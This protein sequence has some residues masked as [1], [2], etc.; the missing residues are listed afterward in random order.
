MNYSLF[1]IMSKFNCK[2]QCSIAKV[3]I[4]L[5]THFSQ[6]PLIYL[7]SDILIG[8][9]RGE[10][11]IGSGNMRFLLNLAIDGVPRLLTSHAACALC[12]MAAIAARSCIM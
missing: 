10:G 8:S 5:F 4:R 6:A 9:G 2:T 11:H 12:S 7:L 3:S 1:T